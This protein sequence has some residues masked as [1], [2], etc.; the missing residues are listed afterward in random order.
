MRICS[1]EHIIT[2][3]EYIRHKSTPNYHCDLEILNS[4]ILKW[5][6][7][8]YILGEH[9]RGKKIKEYDFHENYEFAILDKE[10][11]ENI[12]FMPE[13]ELR[14]RHFAVALSWDGNKNG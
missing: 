7:V 9:W 5:C 2:G 11:F 13:E 14:R 6:D 8:K 1:R 3:D 10:D 12:D 4:L